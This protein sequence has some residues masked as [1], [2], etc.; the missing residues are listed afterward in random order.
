MVSLAHLPAFIPSGT[1][2]RA[3]DG[4]MRL[5]TAILLN[6]ALVSLLATGATAADTPRVVENPDRGVWDDTPNKTF[7][8]L[9]NLMLG[10][11]EGDD[12]FGRIGS[13]AVDSRGRMIILD[14][15]FVAV[16]IYDP[17]A[18]TL[19]EFGR[20]GEGPG[21]FQMPAKLCVDDED[22]IHVASRN[23]RVAIFSPQGEFLDEFRHS[24]NLGIPLGIRVA[25][26]ETYLVCTQPSPVEL[27][28]RFD[29]K[30]AFVS[31]FSPSLAAVEHVAPNEYLAR[32]GGVIDI[33]PDGTV[34][35]AQW[36]PYE[37]RTFTPDGTLLLTVHREN[38]FVKVP[39]IKQ[40]SDGGSFR[41]YGG[42]S[43]ILALGNDLMMHVAVCI[44]D[45]DPLHQFTMV[46]LFDRDGRLLKSRRLHGIVAIAAIDD[47]RQLYAIESR[48]YPMVVRYN[49]RLP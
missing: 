46:D 29:R 25:G 16:K 14:V 18:S 48:D 17:E 22:R 2:I 24:F 15:G 1:S 42:A 3:G 43:A 36:S 27:V 37:I 19:E 23:G 26:Q 9:E 44:P 28:H 49:L 11:E 13:L 4:I 39:E 32:C 6:C 12:A 35:F 8:I 45:D 47:A 10:S 33:A 41:F 20:E 21:E 5:S 31:S 30:H 34:L 7:H 38:S 40:T